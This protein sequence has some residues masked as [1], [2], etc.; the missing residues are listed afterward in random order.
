[1][2]E[3]NI[4]AA[5]WNAWMDAVMTEF[6]W[7][8]EKPFPKETQKKRELLVALTALFAAQTCPHVAARVVC[9]MM[10]IDTS[11]DPDPCGHDD[12]ARESENDLYDPDGSEYDEDGEDDDE[13]VY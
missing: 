12:P 8:A 7:L 5:V 2:S 1:M 13:D 6:I 10:G 3:P 4:D 11:A 9:G